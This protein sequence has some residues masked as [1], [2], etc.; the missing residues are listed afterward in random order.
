[1]HGEHGSSIGRTAEWPE[2]GVKVMEAKV[3]RG[4][5]KILASLDKV[6]LWSIR[7][8]QVL[9]VALLLASLVVPGA[10]AF[11]EGETPPDEAAS[12]L[13]A[14]FTKLAKLFINVMYGLIMLA[15][16]VGTVKAGLGAQASTAFGLAGRVS[17]EMMNLVGGV[18]IFAIAVMALPLA[19]MVIDTV[20]ENVFGGGFSVE[21]HN[22]F[23]P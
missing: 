22:P 4:Y 23:T 1:M 3:E 12:N 11:A 7:I 14:I 17:M 6:E 9:V 16:A 19:N 21:I 5:G 18:V 15:F 10:N 20:T 8:A 13:L 2:K